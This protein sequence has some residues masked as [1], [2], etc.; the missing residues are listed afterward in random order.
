ML[1]GVIGGLTVGTA[2]SLVV[3]AALSAAF[4]SA[5]KAPAGRGVSESL[6]GV[7]AGDSALASSQGMD[8]SR[9]SLEVVRPAFPAAD[10]SSGLAA[11]ADGS[12]Q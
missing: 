3:L 12:S 5:A 1:R 9:P 2:L 11:G 7:A 4:D 6:F 10:E 8:D